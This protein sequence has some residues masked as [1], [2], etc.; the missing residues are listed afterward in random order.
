V[1]PFS[2]VEGDSINNLDPKGLEG[3]GGGLY[4][5][6]GAKGSW[7]TVT[8]CENGSLYKIDYLTAC[9]G[10]GIGLPLKLP[11]VSLAGRYLLKIQLSKD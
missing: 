1:N 6:A 7:N 2:Y 4:I 9:G 3:I 11:P 10:V 8:C 5:V